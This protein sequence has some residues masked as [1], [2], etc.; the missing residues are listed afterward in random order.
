VHA[1]EPGGEPAELGST[2][3]VD[4]TWDNISGFVEFL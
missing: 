3:V 2:P 1:D 4:F